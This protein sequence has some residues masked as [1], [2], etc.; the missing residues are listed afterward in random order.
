MSQWGLQLVI[1]KL[2]TDEGFRRHFE[3][4]GGECLVRLCE[5]GVDLSETE[6]A[7]LVEASPQLWSRMA[8][9]I[10]CGLRN[11]VATFERDGQGVVTRLGLREQQV[12]SG[13][14]EG[15]TNKEIATQVGVS[16]SSVKATLQRLF[17]KTRVRTRA[18]LVRIAV[19]GAMGAVRRIR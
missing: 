1:G 9:Q 18:Q 2:I 13:V 6:I 10:H 16:E 5:R 3:E 4:R 17:R 8:T 15:L 11:V 19:E 14:F 12:L 7:A